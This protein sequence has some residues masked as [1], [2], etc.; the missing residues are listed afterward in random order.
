MAWKKNPIKRTLTTE[1]VEV[2]TKS[3]IDNLVEEYMTTGVMN[4]IRPHIKL[5]HNNELPLKCTKY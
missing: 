2:A 4:W 5:S 1:V 3:N